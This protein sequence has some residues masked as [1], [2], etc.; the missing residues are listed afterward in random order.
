M[1][2]NSL[3]CIQNKSL[4]VAVLVNKSDQSN[5]TI[6]E[7]NELFADELKQMEN[8]KVFLTSA[9]TGEGIEDAFSF[10]LKFYNK[11]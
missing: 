6:E 2:S 7:F 3:Q 4:P 10:I 1:L 8:G 9:V 5:R 11:K